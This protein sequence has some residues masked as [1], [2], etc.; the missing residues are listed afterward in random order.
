MASRLPKLTELQSRVRDVYLHIDID[1]LDSQEAP[2]V[3][4]RSPNGLSSNEVEQV[5]QMI[6]E[7]F[8]MKVA[9]LTTYNPEYDEDSKIL[10]IGLRLLNVIADAVDR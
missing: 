5:V 3:D 1:V 7:R 10:Q 6:T 4:F 9:A 8:Q 2:G